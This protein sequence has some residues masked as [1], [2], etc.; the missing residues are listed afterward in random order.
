MK[1]WI[2]VCLVL[3]LAG[4]GWAAK[5]AGAKKAAAPV[6]DPVLEAIL[7]RRSIRNYTAQKPEEAKLRQILEAS[8]YAPSA[9]NRQDWAVRVLTEDKDIQQ[10]KGSVYN[11]P[12]VIIIANPG[13]KFG[14][15]DTGFLAQ[16]I[17]LAAHAQGLG[18]C[19]VGSILPLTAELEKKL[20]LPEGY[21]PA[22]GILIGYPDQRP[23]A[24][25]RDLSKIR[26]I[27]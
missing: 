21:A 15:M 16:N 26:F 1:K 14:D 2:I 7:N 27:K 24:P 5:A 20:E 3:G 22:V 10:L 11:A 4:A 19:V 8:V 25:A 12:A 13:G 6:K 17:L 18:T 23:E 9:M